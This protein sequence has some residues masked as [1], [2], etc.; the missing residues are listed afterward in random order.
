MFNLP[1]ILPTS[2]SCSPDAH[3]TIL[4]SRETAKLTTPSLLLL[5][6]LARPANESSFWLA[7]RILPRNAKTI[8]WT[9]PTW[10]LAQVSV[11]TEFLQALVVSYEQNLP[12]EICYIVGVLAGRLERIGL[13]YP[14]ALIA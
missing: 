2:K 3:L 14:Q 9:S 11:P 4:S 12:R 1:D 8:Q 6:D 7:C 5:S 13:R 10:L